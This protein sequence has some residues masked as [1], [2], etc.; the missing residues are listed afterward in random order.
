MVCLWH[1]YVLVHV[2]KWIETAPVHL[3]QG[4]TASL[5]C[6]RVVFVGRWIAFHSGNM[7]MVGIWIAFHNGNPYLCSWEDTCFVVD[8]LATHGFRIILL[9]CLHCI[10]FAL[11]PSLWHLSWPRWCSCTLIIMYF[12]L[13]HY[14]SSLLYVRITDPTPPPNFLWGIPLTPY[15]N[16]ISFLR[17]IRILYLQHMYVTS[18]CIHT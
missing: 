10:L 3:L 8:F 2:D 12:E 18:S 7:D 1:L 13:D 5:S 17:W 15:S 9:N 16:F 4:V 6:F 14:F 11:I